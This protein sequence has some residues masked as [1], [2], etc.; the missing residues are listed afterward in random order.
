[1][2]FVC[3]CRL[4]SDIHKVSLLIDVPAHSSVSEMICKVI[5]SSTVVVHEGIEVKKSDAYLNS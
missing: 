4:S 1:M 3:P 2:I 5:D